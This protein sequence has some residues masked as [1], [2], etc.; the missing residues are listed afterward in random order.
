MDPLTGKGLACDVP[1]RGIHVE[2]G[3]VRL[4]VE[5]GYPVGGGL[6]AELEARIRA[7]L[8]DLLGAREVAVRVT[9]KIA[10]HVAQPGATRR[11]PEVRNLIVVASGKGGVGKSATA[12]NLALALATE[13]ARVGL[14][15]AD[16]YGPSLPGMLGLSGQHPAREDGR[17]RPLMACGVQVMSIGF[18]A[19]ENAP[20][21]WRSP[22]VTR[23]LFQLL[24]ET[25]W[26]DLDYLLAD[27]PPGTGDTQLSLAQQAPI[28]GAVMVTTP[29][30]VALSDVRR[31]MRMFEKVGVRILG[32]VENMGFY[33]CPHC[34]REEAIFGAGGGERLCAE[35]G[36]DCLGKLPLDA[37][38]RAAGDNGKPIVIDAPEAPVTRIYRDIARQIAGKI[39]ALPRDMRARFPPIAIE[40]APQKPGKP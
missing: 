33:V 15:D 10:A 25:R 18:L 11:L 37:R 29:Q 22:L 23:A 2:N 3:G 26:D 1:I 16:I 35:F 32:V 31:G 24:Y 36:V 13:G 5:V 4:A 38:I 40:P 8:I 30:D 20:I 19:E 7:H 14:L 6:C 21:I 17:M 34:G 9:G 27:M 12:V 28:T 39:A